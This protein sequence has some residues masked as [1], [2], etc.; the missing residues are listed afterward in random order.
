M[1]VLEDACIL[2]WACRVWLLP[3][4]VLESTLTSDRS[5]VTLSLFESGR[6]Y[7]SCKTSITRLEQ[8]KLREASPV[9]G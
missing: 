5:H 9:S 8:L 2:F 4:C 7:W 6:N 1:N 3:N